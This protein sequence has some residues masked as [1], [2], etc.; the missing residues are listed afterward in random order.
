MWLFNDPPRQ[1]LKERY[2]FEPTAEWLEHVRKASIRFNSGG[3]GS[4]VSA[5]GLIIT[6]HHVGSGDLQKLSDEHHDYVIEGYHARTEAE[7]K[8][9]IDLELNVL[10]EIEDVTARVN[11]AVKSSMN[12]GE[13]FAARRAV[14][15]EIE[16]ESLKKTGLRS[17]VVTLYQG[18]E[19]HLYRYKR[20]TDVRLVFAPE[21]QAAFF[22]G[23]PDNFEFPRFNLDICLF[24]AYENGQPAKIEHYLRWSGQGVA[25]N[26]L[27]FVSGH[28]GRTS[29]Q[30]TVSELEYLRDESFPFHLAQLYRE[31][32][33]L[34]AWSGRSEENARRA[35]E[36][37]FGVQNG[38]KAS[39]GLEAGLLDP[40]LFAAKKAAEK[41][42]LEAVAAKPEMKDA[43]PAWDQIRSAQEILAKEHR[44]HAMFEREGGFDSKLFAIARTLLRATE[45]KAKPS[46]ERLREF[47]D[48]NRE[49]LELRL[50]SEEP[51][52][53]D[54]ETV[55]LSSSL[56]ALE[57]ILGAGH[58]LV[59]QVLA[60]NPPRERAAE[61]I[62]GT[63]LADVALR[64]KLYGG[65]AVELAAQHDPMIELARLIDPESRRLRKIEETQDEVKRQAYAKIAA[66][67][68]ALEKGTTYPDATF[69]L[70]LA[71]G[72]ARGYEEDGR[73]VPYQTTF[74]GFYERAAAHH[75]KPPFDLPPRWVER[76]D[77]LDLATPFNFVSTADIIGGNS[78][79]PV[80]NRAG[81][82][83]GIIFDGNI[84]S[85]VLD[86][87]YADKQARAVS[88]NSQ[89]IT[90]ALRK[91]YNASGLA[92][93][94][95][96]GVRKEK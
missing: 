24:R 25:E 75:D 59:A 11:G 87:A 14:T 95:I 31:E 13:A 32:V 57:E 34:S 82:F 15:A 26:E 43:L 28:P 93:E 16:N 47:R 90:E 94:L 89:S 92:D 70:R 71:F 22:G 21:M 39:E 30:L 35:K 29:R 7:E 84:Q 58:G 77:R 63:R 9:C 23:D 18:G 96:T 42:L 78:G 52:Y 91:V 83:V 46:G 40:E 27:V 37:L 36:R 54:F 61:L 53:S 20:Y 50:F 69:T 5:D 85:L 66:A 41:K 12:A 38:R 81:E 68:F 86:F 67:R 88:V 33:V 45:E 17:D 64:K 60:G 4:F 49:S 76:K 56:A 65:S 80:V 3:S 8:R 51:I 6:N 2:G 44:A 1:L 10:M 19:Y 55:K 62:A 72:T 73:R 48:S 79:S 74:V